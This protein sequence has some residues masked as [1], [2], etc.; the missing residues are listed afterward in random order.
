MLCKRKILRKHKGIFFCFPFHTNDDDDDD[1]TVAF[2]S[3]HLFPKPYTVMVGRSH[4]F[5]ET[6]D[7]DDERCWVFFSL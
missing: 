4:L 7:D 3:S 1:E 5:F 2:A 6:D